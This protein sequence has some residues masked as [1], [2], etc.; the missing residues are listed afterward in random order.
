MRCLLDTHTLI[1]WMTND[2][3]LS[4]SAHALIENKH[5]FSLVSAASAWEIAT[6]VRLGRL[7]A[8]AGLV[9]DFVA[10]L[11]R[12][13][14]GILPVSADHG[15]RAGLLPGPH[16]DP[17]DRMLIAQAIAE[18]IPLVSNDRALDGYGVERLW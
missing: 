1:W 11:A 15:L 2:S 8:A 9:Q 18:N 10:D 3:H 16:T 17:F 12:H 5:N 14:I 4:K 7:P 13:R 6:K